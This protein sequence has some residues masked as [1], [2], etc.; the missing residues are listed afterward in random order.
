MESMQA[1]VQIGDT[2]G[3]SWMNLSSGCFYFFSDTRRKII[4]KAGDLRREVKVA[5]EI[6][7]TRQL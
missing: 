3:G 2:I 6:E 1:Q 5:C 7:W 4:T